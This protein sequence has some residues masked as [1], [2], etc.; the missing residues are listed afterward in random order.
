MEVYT[1]FDMK[2]LILVHTNFDMNTFITN[3]NLVGTRL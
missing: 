2:T 3:I 1:K